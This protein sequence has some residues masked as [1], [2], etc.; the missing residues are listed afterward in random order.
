MAI[1]TPNIMIRSIHGRIGNLVFYYRRRAVNGAGTQC[2]RM[3]VIPR[4]PDTEAQRRVRCAFRNAVLSWQSMT[5]DE[6]Y[7]FNRK[8]RFMNMSGYNLYISQ[9]MRSKIHA[10]A[11]TGIAP[12][13]S[14]AA[15]STAYLNPLTSVSK[16]Y[17]IKSGIKEDSIHA[18]LHPG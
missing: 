18:K 17:S 8:A 13:A 4:N 9:Y 10:G 16:S 14:S 5:A 6:K 12:A 7:A 2:V 3:H 1:A 11:E 15:F